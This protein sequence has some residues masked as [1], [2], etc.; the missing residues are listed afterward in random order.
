MQIFEIACKTINS[1]WGKNSLSL[2]SSLIT[3]VPLS[4]Y[5]L[6]NSITLLEA[7]L[8]QDDVTLVN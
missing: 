8:K 3:L 6:D 5:H 1:E 4:S 7:V 2:L